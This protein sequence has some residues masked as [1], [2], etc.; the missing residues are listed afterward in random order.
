MKEIISYTEL[1]SAS[2]RHKILHTHVRLRSNRHRE[3]NTKIKFQHSNNFHYSLS[4][5]TSFL[6]KPKI[7][8][9][10]PTFIKPGAP[11]LAG[12]SSGFSAKAGTRVNVSTTYFCPPCPGAHWDQ[13][14]GFDLLRLL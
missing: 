10:N 7:P 2:T 14:I 1:I 6:I 5:V 9:A 8:I 3:N 4:L 13:L 12:D 11:L